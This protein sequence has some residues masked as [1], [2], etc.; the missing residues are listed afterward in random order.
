LQLRSQPKKKLQLRL[1]IAVKKTLKHM[2][3]KFAFEI[4]FG[5][6]NFDAIQKCHCRDFKLCN[7]TITDVI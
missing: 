4:T 3:S 1:H 6:W 7:I 5:G 2:T